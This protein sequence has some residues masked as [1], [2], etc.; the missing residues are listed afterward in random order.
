MS[1]RKSITGNAEREALQKNANFSKGGIV[2]ADYVTTVSD[3]YAQEIKMPFYGESLD[4]LMRARSNSLE[5]IVNGIDYNEYNPETDPFIIQHYNAKN[6][7][8]EKTKNK[9]NILN[10]LLI[11]N[12]LEF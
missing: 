9:T 2:Y 10:S 11:V 3:T 12:S 8:K 4:G 1:G 7:R 6:F 5:G